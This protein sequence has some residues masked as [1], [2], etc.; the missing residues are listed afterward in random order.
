MDKRHDQE[1]PSTAKSRRGFLK[2]AGKLVVY[3]PRC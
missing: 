3:I 1:S 2:T